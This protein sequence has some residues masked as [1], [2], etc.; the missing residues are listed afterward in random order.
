MILKPLFRQLYL[1]G[2]VHSCVIFLNS[3]SLLCIIYDTDKKME[4]EEKEEECFL[5]YLFNCRT[6]CTS[7]YFF[8]PKDLINH[9]HLFKSAEIEMLIYLLD[10]IGIPSVSLSLWVSHTLK[11]SFV[12]SSLHIFEVEQNQCRNYLEVF[13]CCCCYFF[14]VFITFSSIFPWTIIFPGD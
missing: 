12:I 6:A 4:G 2:E 7:I 5:D 10:M 9:L 11:A 14:P 13:C 1:T 3:Y 8:F